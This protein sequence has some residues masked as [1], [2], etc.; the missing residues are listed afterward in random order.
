M[1]RTSSEPRP[2][3][4]SGATSMPT[5]ACPARSTTSSSGR[6]TSPRPNT[7]TLATALSSPRERVVACSRASPGSSRSRADQRIDH[8]VVTLALAQPRVLL[9]E[10]VCSTHQATALLL[11]GAKLDE[12]RREVFV[13]SR[14]DERDH[15]VVEV[16][17]D[18]VGTRADHRQAECDVLEQLDGEHVAR[19]HVV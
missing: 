16:R 3:S 15:R 6:P 1:C 8:R 2:G 5:T 9:E 19:K 17:L 14:L 18:G 10:G 13:A 4:S 11:V 12:L 7:A